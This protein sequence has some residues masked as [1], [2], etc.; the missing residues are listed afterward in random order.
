MLICQQ[1][2]M[3]TS[4]P[5]ARSM[6]IPK[7]VWAQDKFTNNIKLWTDAAQ[8]SYSKIYLEVL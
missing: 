5:G 6:W 2:C 8:L 7:D 1:V 3:H 4:L